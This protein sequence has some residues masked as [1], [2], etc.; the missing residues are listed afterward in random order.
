MR[1]APP[2]GRVRGISSVS[3]PAVTGIFL[4]FVI[5]AYI[6]GITYAFETAHVF[7]ARKDVSALYFVID[8]YH[9]AGDVFAF[10]ELTVAKK[11]MVGHDEIT[12]DK[13]FV[14]Y[15]RILSDR[16]F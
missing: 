15:A 2:A 11:I 10:V 13:R 12:P 4:E 9:A 8:F 14:G 16:D 5:I 6:F 3:R 7:S 1:A